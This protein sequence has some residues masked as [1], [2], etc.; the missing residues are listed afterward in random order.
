MNEQNSTNT[1]FF[2]YVLLH[3]P[4]VFS[5]DSYR[6]KFKHSYCVKKW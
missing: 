5:H 1:V 6:Q 3:V 4:C 2:E